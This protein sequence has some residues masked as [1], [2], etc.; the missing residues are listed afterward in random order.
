MV[1]CG[2]AHLFSMVGEGLSCATRG[3]ALLILIEE[4]V[5]EQVVVDKFLPMSQVGP[6][7]DP[8]LDAWV[9]HD[10]P[11]ELRPSRLLAPASTVHALGTA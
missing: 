4:D 1:G 6:I 2:A 10:L 3:A 7:G 9:G 11:I 8:A 5:A